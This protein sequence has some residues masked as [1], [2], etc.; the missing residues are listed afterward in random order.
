VA[1]LQKVTDLLDSNPYVVV[2][3]LDFSK[4]FDTVRHSCL[5]EKLAQLHIPDNIYNWL[6]NFFNGHSHCTRSEGQTSDLIEINASIIQG[7]AI[8]PASYVV[9]AA[10][11]RTVRADN[12]LIKYADDTYVIIPACNVDSR[13]LEMDHI[14]EWAERNN[15]V[16]NRSKSAE[17]VFTDSRK[18][19][20][21]VPPS[22]LPDIARV[23]SLKVL[24]VTISSSLSLSEHVNS[25]ISSCACSQYA[26]KVLRAHGLCDTASQEVYESVVVDKLLYASPA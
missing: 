10:D 24:G 14:G 18:R 12:Y 8:G 9:Q 17:I 20:S 16:L 26:I 22:P 6:T 19:R 11:L 2:I 15:L 4:A 3:A 5:M 13:Q 25:V 1:L 21:V 23:Q 7:S